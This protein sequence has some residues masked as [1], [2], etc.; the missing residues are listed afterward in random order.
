M[1]DHTTQPFV[2][3]RSLAGCPRFS[4]DGRWVAYVSDESGRSEV[5]VQ[6]YPGPGKK[7]QISTE[8]GIETVWNPN[9]RELF[10]RTG[11]KMMAVDVAARPGFTAGRPTLL[12][13]GAFVQSP[14]CIPNYDVSRDG[15]RFLM[16]QPSPH[17]NVTPIQITIVVN[18][19]DE[20]KRLVPTTK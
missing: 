18:W 1:S 9:G 7:W 11:N 10:Y 3:T 13:T 20:L 15:R 19:F 6:P 5:Y 14:T 12:F 4:P 8:G 2:R 16:I 17:E